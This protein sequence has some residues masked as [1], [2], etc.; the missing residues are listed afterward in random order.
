MKKKSIAKMFFVSLAKS[1]GCIL[2]ILAVGFISYKVSYTILSSESGEKGVRTELKEIQS[3]ASLDDVSKNLIYVTD[4]K[5]RIVH[6]ILEICNKNTHNMDYVT[7]PV[8]TDYTIPSTMYRQLCQINQEI[9]Q[10]IRISKLNTY[11]EKESD[12]YG[13]G[14]LIF[15]KMLGIDISYYTAIKEDVYASHYKEENVTVGFKAKSDIYN[16]PGLDGV[17][18]KSTVLLKTNMKIT[19]LSDAHKR[20]LKDLGGD[21]K[22]ILD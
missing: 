20:Q 12:T 4:D 3:D 21:E 5:E 8:K 2:I 6:L 14:M 9:P 22:K 13:Y 11:F 10:V 17:T 1:I 16:T 18:P 15:E 19:T 7:I